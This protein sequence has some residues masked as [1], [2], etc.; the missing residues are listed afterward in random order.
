MQFFENNL[1][2]V[3]INC[4]NKAFFQSIDRLE[5]FFWVLILKKYFGQRYE[6][7]RRTNI[8]CEE[9]NQNIDDFYER[10]EWIEKDLDL[11][12]M[13]LIYK[14][15]KNFRNEFKFEKYFNLL[16]DAKRNQVKDVLNKSAINQSFEFSRNKSGTELK[17][18]DENENQIITDSRAYEMGV[19][20][21]TI[22][23][24]ELSLNERNVDKNTCSLSTNS[25]YNLV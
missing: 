2:S 14:T 13:I 17:S 16:I 11:D 8:N 4:E 3:L 5:Y 9:M 1:S 10:E 20:T 7:N 12:S 19:K 6:W 21:Q 18:N 25:T 23:Q 22:S 24:T 15:W